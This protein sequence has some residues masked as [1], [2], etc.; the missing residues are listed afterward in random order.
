MKA[1]EVLA[2]YAKGE[3]NFQWVN[4]RGQ[5]FKGENLSGADFSRADIRS[6]NFTNA[7]LQGTTFFRAKCGL[8]KRWV[9]LLT[10][11]SW[12]IALISGC[13]SIFYNASVSSILESSLI[14]Q[15]FGWVALLVIVIFLIL[16]I[17]HEI[18][19]GVVIVTIICAAIFAVAVI[20]GLVLSGSVLVTKIFVVV[21]LGGLLVTVTGLGAVA[22]T[23]AAAA[24]MAAALAVAGEIL[25]TVT[26][27]R[28]FTVVLTELGTE[29]VVKAGACVGVLL[30]AVSGAQTFTVGLESET[31]KV[32]EAVAIVITF[33]G[34]YVGW[35]A[36]TKKLKDPWV[37]NFAI[38]FAS[39]GGTSFYGADLTDANF[40][41]TKLKSTDM[42]KAILTRVR[43]HKTKM[44]DC[45]RYGNT[46]LQNAQ[47]REWLIGKGTDKNFNGQELKGVNFQ[48]ADL[49]NASFINANLSEANLRNV[50][51]SRAILV[52]TQLDGTDLTGAILM[53]ACIEDCRIT[54]YTK[55]DNVECEYIFMGSPTEEDFNPRRKP[56][57]WE[58]NFVGNDFADFI[59][60]IFNTLD[61]Y[62]NRGVDSRAIAISWQKL[63]EDNPDAKLKFSSM[64]V[65]G[66]NNLLIRLK[67]A[68]NVNLAQLCTD[69]FKTYNQ[70]KG[71]AEEELKKSIAERDSRIKQLEN[72]VN[73]AFKLPSFYAEQYDSQEN[74]EISGDK[75]DIEID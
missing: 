14:D 38:V 48:D 51:L 25:G 54:A 6:T 36:M 68:P 12:F 34:A 30:V 70:L 2:R 1:S 42:R 19:I 39:V 5:S 22:G 44:L 64:E 37:L 75:R 15:I 71:L 7:N 61:L 72:M 47:V 8:Q 74:S 59:K 67:T 17:R 9:I 60:P 58:K 20:L 13:L 55:L 56:D 29:S 49:T 11:L 62:H 31:D 24:A 69:Y 4:L 35:R 28:I 16:T 73:T 43:W 66:E 10:I 45:V 27:A 26:G 40:S 57:N 21:T 52:Q 50:N 63:A 18:R 3:R 33:V 41:G 23:L 46:Y 32:A 53:G 65:K